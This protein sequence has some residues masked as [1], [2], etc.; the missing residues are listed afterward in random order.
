MDDGRY[1][2]TLDEVSA[3]I[4]AIRQK[5]VPCGLI[6]PRMEAGYL[7]ADG[8]ALL[9]SEKD[10][11][12]FYIGGAGMDGMYLRTPQRYE[13]VRDDSGKITAFRR[14]SS[15]LTQFNSQELEA[16]FQ[17]GLNTKENLLHD[18]EAVVQAV[19]QPEIRAAFSGARNKLEPIP[20]EECRRLMA[21]IRAAYKGRH[22]QSI[23]QRQRAAGKSKR[24]DRE[25]QW[26]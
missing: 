9:E 12:G 3:E 11:N 6:Q 21:D 17:Y 7:L 15:Y 4:I 20:P 13:P 18:L 25:R 26:R 16:I 24:R 5:G 23:R 2:M 8:T 10:E 1:A 14:M 22:E 19:K